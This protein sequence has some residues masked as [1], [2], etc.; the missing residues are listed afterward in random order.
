[1]S[2][3]MQK[4]TSEIMDYEDVVKHYTTAR[5]RYYHKRKSPH[6]KT[7]HKEITDSIAYFNSRIRHFN[8]KIRLLNK[9]MDEY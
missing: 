3:R 7:S 4:K 5:S 8:A 1:M 9:W 2:L 6:N